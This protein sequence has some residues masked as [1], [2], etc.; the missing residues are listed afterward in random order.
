MCQ[1]MDLI[2]TGSE[3]Y[4]SRMYGHNAGQP[5]SSLCTKYDSMKERD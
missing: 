2:E 4:K 3:L 1:M 5:V